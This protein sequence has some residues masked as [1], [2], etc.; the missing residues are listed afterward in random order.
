M[1]RD[2]AIYWLGI[3]GGLAVALGG[4]FELVQK[5]FPGLSAA[6]EGRIEL[7]AFIVSILSAKASMS[8]LSLSPEG[9]QAVV[10]RAKSVD[11]LGA[12]PVEPKP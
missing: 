9:K 3:I 7:V 4:H 6:W 1:Y 12:G 11:S 2:S 10:G 5:A 8:P